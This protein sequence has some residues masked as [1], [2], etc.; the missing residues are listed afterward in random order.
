MDSDHESHGDS[1]SGAEYVRH[2]W[3]EEAQR[4][5]DGGVQAHESSSGSEV[6]PD[7]QE[8][9]F[10]D[11]EGEARLQGRDGPYADS[12]HNV[13]EEQPCSAE[14]SERLFRMFYVEPKD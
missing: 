14:E 7:E 12:G 13:G 1:D 4:I 10:S 5:S 2:L 3:K 6:S 9:S 11:D 8:R